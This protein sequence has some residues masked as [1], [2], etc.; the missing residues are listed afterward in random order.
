[1]KLQQ[2]AQFLDQLVKLK[3]NQYLLIYHFHIIV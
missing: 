3:H 2:S 1:M